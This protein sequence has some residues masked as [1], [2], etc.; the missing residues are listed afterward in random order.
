MELFWGEDFA[1]AGVA[2]GLKGG[3]EGFVGMDFVSEAFARTLPAM[4]WEVG[5]SKVL[6]VLIH[7]NEIL[8]KQLP[9]A[10]IRFNENFKLFESSRKQERQLLFIIFEHESHECNEFI[11][12]SS[13]KHE[14]E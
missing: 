8:I 3:H 13:C 14:N 4:V 9:K 2:G 11:L 12:E 1:G 5:H 7:N 10:G 6:L